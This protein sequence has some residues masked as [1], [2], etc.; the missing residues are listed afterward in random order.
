MRIVYAIILA[1]YLV[2]CDDGKKAEV[3]GGG[4]EVGGGNGG[5]GGG[6]VTTGGRSLAPEIVPES[7]LNKARNELIKAIVEK[8]EIP[9]HPHRW[10]KDMVN[11]VPEADD[12]DPSSLYTIESILDKI[13]DQ[14]LPEAAKDPKAHLIEALRGELH[15]FVWIFIGQSWAQFW[16]PRNTYNTAELLR[17]QIDSASSDSDAIRLKEE[18]IQVLRTA[19]LAGSVESRIHNRQPAFAVYVNGRLGSYQQATSRLDSAQLDGL[20]PSSPLIPWNIVEKGKNWAQ[21]DA[22]DAKAKTEESEL[23]DLIS[24]ILSAEHPVMKAWKNE[25]QERNFA[26][27]HQ[28][29]IAAR[30]E[31]VAVFEI[32]ERDPFYEAIDVYRAEIKVKDISDADR[33]KA[34]EK[35]IAAIPADRAEPIKGLLEAYKK[36][37]A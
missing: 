21:L 1:I 4:N 26:T 13:D 7:P 12:F 24:G 36:A 29:T 17:R 33:I 27:L 32:L 35:L 25:P 8:G 14:S 11:Y 37:K 31:C 2:G 6:L 9:R 10:F 15:A 18:L 20:I 28:A 16:L 3:V 30:D 19:P 5:G 22:N 23:Y 34:Q